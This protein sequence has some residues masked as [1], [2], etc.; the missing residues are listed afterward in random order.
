MQ[1]VRQTLTATLDI[2]SFLKARQKLYRLLPRV[3]VFLLNI[4]R[5]TTFFI[6][7][8]L[9]LIIKYTASYSRKYNMELIVKRQPTVYDIVNSKAEAHVSVLFFH[10]DIQWFGSLSSCAA[11]FVLNSS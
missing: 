7:I 2:A 1:F 9:D 6:I 8:K 4:L 10:Q 3:R 5:T 11:T